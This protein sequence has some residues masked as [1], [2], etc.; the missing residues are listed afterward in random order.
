M[1]TERIIIEVLQE[2]ERAETIHPNYP[3]NEFKALAIWQE[4]IGEVTKA[5]LDSADKGANR[6]EVINES[7]Q[8]IACGVRFLKNLRE[9]EFATDKPIVNIF[10][11]W[12]QNII[13][14]EKLNDKNDA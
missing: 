9:A 8:A 7:I 11:E 5:L 1:K 10:T 2:L 13:D 14:N 12:E 3:T 6:A 4:E